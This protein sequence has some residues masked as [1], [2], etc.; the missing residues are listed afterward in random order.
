MFN[1]ERGESY[2]KFPP[3]VMRGVVEFDRLEREKRTRNQK[4]KGSDIEDS[5]QAAAGAELTAA[6]HWVPIAQEPAQ[7]LVDSD[8]EE[9]EEVEVTDDED[10]DEH[11]SKRHKTQDGDNQQPVEFDEDDIAFQL[12]ALGEDYGLDP[13]EYG[14]GEGEELEEGAEGLA[15][16]EG[17]MKALF[18][19]MLND[20]QISPYTTWEKII[21]AGHIIEDDRYT[22]LPNMR[23]RKEVW[24]EWSRDRIQQL[25]EQRE[26]EEKK[27]PR[28]PYFAFLESYATPKLYWPEFRRKYRTEA[29]MR[30][31]KILDKD[32]EKWYREYIG[33]LKLPES[34]LK[35][36]LVQLLKS[37]S[38]HAL[39]RS[40][41]IN[42]LPPALLT[43][44]RYV[45]VRKSI[46]DPLVE[47]HISA[48]PPAPSD[49][50]ISP[51]EEEARAKEIQDR[52]RRENALAERQKQVEQE[53]RR[54]RGALQFSKGILRDEEEEIQKAMRVGKEGLLSHMEGDE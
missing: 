28:I 3:E 40:V 12:A 32:R 23:S 17:D 10:D 49:L 48:L 11:R 54:Q 4:A 29:A 33:R 1:P 45:S 50:E 46:R 27:D 36:D 7:R 2:W 44:L 15:L 31:T 30:G 39:N 38:L 8:G 16:T 52:E 13:G 41:T 18:K 34:T 21:E 24:D 14:D 20:F 37:T 26:K 53:K 19:D 6:E 43:D 42:T 47:A 22:V 5:D 9:L 51:E 25:R 35:A